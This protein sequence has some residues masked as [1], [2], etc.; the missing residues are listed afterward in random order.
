MVTLVASWVFRRVLFQNWPVALVAL[1]L[2]AP[3]IA[4][5]GENAI[6][7]G[8]Y[9]KTLLIEVP[10]IASE[11]SETV[12]L[13]AGVAETLGDDGLNWDP[14]ED[15]RPLKCVSTGEQLVVGT[16]KSDAVY[17][18]YTQARLR[19]NE[20]GTL[21]V[22]I[23]Q[24]ESLNPG[25]YV[26][27]VT[28]RLWHA[29][30]DKSPPRPVKWQVVVAVHG[31]RLLDTDFS[32]RA[33][34]RS[35]RV[36]KSAAVRFKVYTVGCDLGQGSLKLDWSDDHKQSHEVALLIHLP[37][38]DVIDPLEVFAGDQ[39]QHCHPQWR[40]SPMYVD[41][42]EHDVPAEIVPTASLQQRRDVPR[43]RMYEVEFNAP[44]CF[45][46]GRMQAHVTWEQSTQA[47]S[48]APLS[49]SSALEEVRSGIIAHPTE[50]FVNERAQVHVRSKANLGGEFRLVV[51]GPQR[52]PF[53]PVV[54][55]RRQTAEVGGVDPYYEY[56]GEFR[57][58][59]F[60]TYQLGWPQDATVLQAN[61]E[62]PATLE[63][64]I[65][66]SGNLAERIEVFSSATPVFWP[67]IPNPN[68]GGGYVTRRTRAMSFGYSSRY[69][70]SATVRETGLFRQTRGGQLVPHNP[71]LEPF[72]SAVQG[73][74]AVSGDEPA[75]WMIPENGSLAFDLIV[76]VH[77]RLPAD[78][79]RHKR[80]VRSYVWR[81]LIEAEDINHRRIAR[82]CQGHFEVKV[83]S[84]WEYH[85][86]VVVIAACFVALIGATLLVRRLT[87]G[88]HS[89]PTARGQTVRDVEAALQSGSEE[90]AIFDRSA[91]RVSAP[92]AD[93]QDEKAPEAA[94]A[95]ALR[96]GPSRKLDWPQVADQPRSD[97][98]ADEEGGEF[99]IFNR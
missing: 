55:T 85:S 23:S 88:S 9:Q 86:I 72:I 52:Q 46:P 34:G 71:D 13:A 16:S 29:D 48:H 2:L 99:D 58:L 92:A 56:Q 67:L 5:S 50:C 36:G 62:E 89:V 7:V 32:R 39:S 40:D 45:L 27:E 1:V 18:T 15:L 3:G 51:S 66:G 98:S 25:V 95:R 53:E 42:V 22:G 90:D 37:F 11:I 84:D 82:I 8:D 78:H 97:P 12:R 83:S 24:P 30:E 94:D 43:Q 10:G 87:L 73:E 33:S 68:K 57:P 14:T 75:K 76:S 65:H 91:N 74:T 77:P 20:P 54:M 61:L 49:S 21:I 47:N 6:E 60:G 93:S 96:G 59:A 81:G 19:Q 26:G 28:S 79:P 41:V 44:D 31:R 38:K 80:G 69:L 64:R 17:V 70:R 35:L 63:V 4:A